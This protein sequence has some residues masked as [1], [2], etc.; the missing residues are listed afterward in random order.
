MSLQQIKT[1]LNGA[2]ER[3]P[4][5]TLSSA[6]S[7]SADV[8]SGHLATNH[9][10]QPSFEANGPSIIVPVNASLN[11]QLARQKFPAASLELF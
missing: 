8:V 4:L 7:N 10:P 6:S 9:L 11:G 1:P 2:S 5:K 3:L